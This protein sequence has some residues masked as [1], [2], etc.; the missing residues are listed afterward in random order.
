M[1]NLVLV[2]P[3]GAG[4]GSAAKDLENA[5]NIKHIST[6]DIFRYHI[7]NQTELGKRIKK[8][9]DAGDLVPSEL[10][11]EVMQDRVSQEDCQNGFILDG[12]PRNL[13]Q[14]KCLDKFA[15]IDYV[16]LLEIPREISIERL[17]NRRQCKNCNAIYNVKTN[18]PKESG[19]CDVCGGE[20]YQRDDDKP[21]AIENRLKIY[22]KETKPILDYYG[23]KVVKVDALGSISEVNQRIIKNVKQ[24]MEKNGKN[25][26][27]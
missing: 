24:K 1:L 23:D 18:P 8:I 6:G 14:A 11:C 2:G 22:E 7:K 25:H 10:T 9:V 19:V 15:D 17:S 21:E 12:F 4:K 13:E 3:Q 5:F 16:V 27:K 26:S 20:L